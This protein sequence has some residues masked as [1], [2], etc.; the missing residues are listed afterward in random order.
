VTEPVAELR[1]VSRV[2]QMGANEV[3]ALDAF[4]FTFGAGEYWS[5][6]GASGSGKSTLL[7]ILGC[8]DRP[9]HGSYRIRG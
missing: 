8:I 1:E 9:T 5:I 2:Y 4:S 7:N 6:M 3:S